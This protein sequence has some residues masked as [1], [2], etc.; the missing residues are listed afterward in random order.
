MD[1][2]ALLPNC[3]GSLLQPSL[4]H[5]VS[6]TPL[7]AAP[8]CPVA[9]VAEFCRC[10]VKPPRDSRPSS[11]PDPR[12]QAPMPSGF[13]ASPQLR[14]LR[15]R[16]TTIPS[17]PT[18]TLAATAPFPSS[19]VICPGKPLFRARPRRHLPCHFACCNLAGSTFLPVT[20]QLNP[21]LDATRP[22]SPPPNLNPGKAVPAPTLS[23]VPNSRRLYL[24]ELHLADGTY[25]LHPAPEDGAVAE[26]PIPE[27]EATPAKD[28]FPS[29][30]LE[31]KPRSMHPTF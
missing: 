1:Q 9:A 19:P 28:Q 13:S 18:P 22:R 26:P 12:L 20:R 23:P 5:L 14:R 10:C 11:R 21:P 7:L 16:S 31:G 2:R 6:L 27:A 24:R 25:E 4:P 17:S 30:P 3:S 15:A 8:K 29:T